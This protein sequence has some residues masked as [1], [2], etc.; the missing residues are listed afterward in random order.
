MCGQGSWSFPPPDKWIKLYICVT[1]GSFSW[2]QTGCGSHTCNKILMS[3]SICI[4]TC[5]IFACKIS[6]HS[7]FWK[8]YGS[9]LHFKGQFCLIYSSK[10]YPTIIIRIWKTKTVSNYQQRRKSACHGRNSFLKATKCFRR[11][12]CR[13]VNFGHNFCPSESALNRPNWNLSSG[14]DLKFVEQESR[15]YVLM[16]ISN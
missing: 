8:M 7:H 13:F 11:L 6:D 1:C 16:R 2:P 5:W 12:V 9:V 3:I 10:F 15:R 4:K 14:S